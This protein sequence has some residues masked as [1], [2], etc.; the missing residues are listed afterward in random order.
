MKNLFEIAGAPVAPEQIG[1]SREQWR[2]M[3]NF[4][5]LMRWRVNLFDLAKRAQIFDTLVGNVFGKG[6][7]LEA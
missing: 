4:V 6:G 7:A 1:V 2:N 5:Q 3:T